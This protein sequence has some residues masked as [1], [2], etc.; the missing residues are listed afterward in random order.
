[1]LQLWSETVAVRRR[2]IYDGH[3]TGDECGPN[4]RKFVLEAKSRKKPH[5]DIDPTGDRT[6]ALYVRSNDVAPRSRR[7]FI[8]DVTNDR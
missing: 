2:M 8:R 4:L 6:R 1:M 7:E 5:Q 3:I